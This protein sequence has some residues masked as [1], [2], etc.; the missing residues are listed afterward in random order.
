MVCY[1][2][3]RSRIS[4]MINQPLPMTDSE[5]E[6]AP[7]WAQEDEIV[8]P[9]PPPTIHKG[10][11]QKS[12]NAIT[13]PAPRHSQGAHEHRVRSESRHGEVP[14][15]VGYG[16]AV[17]PVTCDIPRKGESMPIG[18][19]IGGAS[20]EPGGANGKDRLKAYVW[21]LRTQRLKEELRKREQPIYGRKEQL[22]KRLLRALQETS[23][24]VP[25]AIPDAFLRKR[26]RMPGRRT[27]A[28]TVNEFARLIHVLREDDVR[29][30]LL[31]SVRPRSRIE[32]EQN[33]SPDAFWGVLVEP[34]FNDASYQPKKPW[35]IPI[36]LSDVNPSRVETTRSAESLKRQYQ[37]IRAIFTK[38]YS[39][40]S[41]SGQNDPENFFEFTDSA[42]NIEGVSRKEQYHFHFLRCGTPLEDRALIEIVLRTMP[43]SCQVNEGLSEAESSVPESLGSPSDL[44][45]KDRCTSV[46]PSKGREKTKKRRKNVPGEV[47]GVLMDHLEESKKSVVAA[48]NM[49]SAAIGN[50]LPGPSKRVEAMEE[51]KSELM[52]IKQLIELDNQ[53]KA[54]G[55][56]EDDDMRASFRQEMKML[57]L[58]TKNDGKE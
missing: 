2:I 12:Q 55:A 45:R 46:E 3:L 16:R 13:P 37:S 38:H 44:K 36:E 17:P 28:F 51:R 25:L 23:T 22:Q 15:R 42:S 33:H 9:T 57:A 54:L 34:L 30:E 4:E 8:E 43:K 5:P 20:G 10:T 40:W 29:K 11:T 47:S 18:E 52:V 26:C 24:E 31:K 21:T 41:Q 48:L 49:S 7:A 1:K 6:G 32:L 19:I 14:N 50:E 35:F 39:N 58:R 27:R 53:L 56:G